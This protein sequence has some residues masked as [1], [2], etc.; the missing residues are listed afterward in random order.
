M[1]DAYSRTELTKVITVGGAG[2]YVQSRRGLRLR[3]GA[4]ATTAE[5]D[6]VLQPQSDEPARMIERE[7]TRIASRHDGPTA[8][9]LR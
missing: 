8:A 9:S 6:I 1:V 3:P 5:T 4:Q 2:G 7:L